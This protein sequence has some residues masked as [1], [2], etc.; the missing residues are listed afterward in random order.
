MRGP[1]PIKPCLIGEETLFDRKRK[2]EKLMPPENASFDAIV[3]EFSAARAIGIL[4]HRRPDGDAIGSCLALAGALAAL[5]KEVHIVNDDAVPDG[6]RFL[7]GSDAIRVAAEVIAAPIAVDALAVLDAAGADRLSETAWAAFQNRGRVLNLDHHISNTRFGHLNYVDAVSPATG[8]IVYELIRH[9]GWPLPESTRDSVYAAISTD[10]GSF[11][12]PN[13]TGKTY[14]IAAEL[15]EAGLNVGEMNRL[16]YESYPL[17]RLLLMRGILRDMEI[18]DDGRVVA[19]KLTRQMADE[20]GM[21]P[22]DTEGIIDV[23]RSVDSVIVAVMFEEMTD[24]K[25]RVS[26]RSKST[27]MDVGAICAVFG[28][29]GHT[30]AAGTRMA[31]P[32]DA[33]AE[34]FLKEVSQRLDGKHD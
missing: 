13:T 29:G 2:S 20:A 31:G 26:S 12:Y 11:R 34:R 4:S 28:G 5:G 22:G 3:A 16:L 23:I 6:L 30:L 17:R 21:E 8:Q 1:F 27:A 10:T 7:P 15:I 18:H 33:A 19:A 9:A 25:I 32:I 14:R 24:G